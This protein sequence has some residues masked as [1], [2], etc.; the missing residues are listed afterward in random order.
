MTKLT[1]QEFN[2]LLKNRTFAVSLRVI[3]VVQSLPNNRVGWKIGDQLIRSG[4][5][6]GALTEEACMGVSYKDFING[7]RM[8]RKE[9]SETDF[10]LRL[11]IA[12]GLIPKIRL[13]SL[14][15]E[16]SEIIAILTSIV[17]SSE[18]K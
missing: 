13:Q 5:A 10:W 11:I 2:Q 16:I 3:K 4:T 15:Q 14:R 8:T 18:K 7:I 17:K 9:A 6:I 1:N 12:A